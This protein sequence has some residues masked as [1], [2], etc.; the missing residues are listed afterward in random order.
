MKR[1]SFLRFLAATALW[2]AATRAQPAGKAP[3]VGYLFSFAPDEGR[4]L[5]EA[6]RA[7]LRE[8][9]HVEGRSIVLVPRWADGH[10]DR[11]PAL[12]D[13]LVREKVDIVVAA[14]TPA[15]LAAKARAGSIPIVMV[16]VADPTHVGL[17]ASFSRP[18]GT[19]TGLSLLTAELGGK[20]LQILAELMQKP[21]RAVA[22][23][24]NPD[25]PSHALFR[26]ETEAAGQ[27]LGVAIRL[28]DARNPAE[29]GRAFETAAKTAV[30]ALVVFDDPVIWSYRKLV[31]AQ[32]R[33]WR[34]PV[35][36][37]YSEFVAEG[38]LISYGP[39][40]PD[41]YRRTASYVDRIL[42]G[43]KP[44]DLPV[45]RPTRFEMAVNLGAAQ[46][47]GLKVPDALLDR[48]DEVIE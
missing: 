24:T 27:Q 19:V 6:C 25:N 35:V 28:L 7:G 48:A 13:E 46:A 11:L 9:G 16:A 20:R 14:A 37:G 21:L 23:I 41:L 40:R 17:V 39:H 43:A 26:E 29:I 2:P 33:E 42:K 4:H 15:N 5:W 36:Y 10:H 31:V 1:R 47:L 3:R 18:G 22:A 34:L 38:G 8:L 30:V 45:E 12:V 32:A 44:G